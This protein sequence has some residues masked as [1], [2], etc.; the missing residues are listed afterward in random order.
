MTHCHDLE[1][2]DKYLQHFVCERY[3]YWRLFKTL[4]DFNW[5]SPEELLENQISLA[6][7]REC[8][9][10]LAFFFLFPKK[11]AASDYLLRFSPNLAKIWKVN[12]GL[13]LDFCG[14]L[15]EG[16]EFLWFNK[17]VPPFGN[18]CIS[19]HLASCQG[20]HTDVLLAGVKWT[21]STVP[22]LIHF[23]R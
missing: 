5:A 10:L 2:V 23:F 17:L 19:G 18:F 4:Y 12:R 13:Y 3:E 15:V 14:L 9:Q 11:L 20:C 21:G 16:G 7:Y 8:K 6:I 1:L 22:S